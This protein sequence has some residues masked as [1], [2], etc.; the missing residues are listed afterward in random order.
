MEKQPTVETGAFEII[1]KLIKMLSEEEL[2]SVNRKVVERLNLMRSARQLHAIA[3][4]SVSDRIVFDYNG[5]D[6]VATIIRLN[7][8][9]VSVIDEYGSSWTIS[10]AFIKKR[11][12]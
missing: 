10:P 8:K 12:A 6:I 7:R 2:H 9:T 3:K 11:L 1:N 5:K 4:H